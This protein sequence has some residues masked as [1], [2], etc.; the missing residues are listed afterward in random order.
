MLPAHCPGEKSSP[1]DGEYRLLNWEAPEAPAARQVAKYRRWSWALLLCSVRQPKLRKL[2]P[3][4]SL[5]LPVGFDGWL[6]VP[7][8]HAPTWHELVLHAS[9]G[10]E[11]RSHVPAR[12]LCELARVSAS[13]ARYGSSC[14]CRRSPVPRAL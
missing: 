3:L 8:E 11:A 9:V 2:V 13:W 10:S 1:V 6:L 7:T 12:V 4:F 5:P 14:P